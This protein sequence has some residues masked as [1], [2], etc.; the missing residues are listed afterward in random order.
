MSNS[1]SLSI[2]YDSSGYPRAALH[3]LAATESFYFLQTSRY[4]SCQDTAACYF[5]TSAYTMTKSTGNNFSLLWLATI[6]LINAPVLALIALFMVSQPYQV[7]GLLILALSCVLFG[8]G[9]ILNHPSQTSYS[10][11]ENGKSPLKRFQHHSRN[12]CALG[13]LFVIF[14]LLCFFIGLAKL[15]FNS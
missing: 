2:A 7:H 8:I 6:A 13:N 5:L 3:S 11:S 1:I 12:A 15:L 10:F 4:N 9:E 14:S